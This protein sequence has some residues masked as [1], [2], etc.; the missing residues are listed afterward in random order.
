VRAAR[1]SQMLVTTHSRALAEQIAT[2]APG[3]RTIELQLHY[4][5]TRIADQR[6]AEHGDDPDD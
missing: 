6:L 3:T 1:G 4:G 5:E 2:L